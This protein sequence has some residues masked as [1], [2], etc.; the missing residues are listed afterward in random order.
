MSLSASERS[1]IKGLKM[2]HSFS[3][4]EKSEIASR[5][6][7]VEMEQGETLFRSGDDAMS[8]YV[9][10]KGELEIWLDQ[11]HIHEKV[12]RVFPGD[13]FGHIAL[14]DGGQRSA[15]CKAARTSVVLELSMFDFA[16]LMSP[17]KPLGFKFLRALTEIVVNQMRTTNDVLTRLAVKEQASNRPRPPTNPDLIQS[18]QEAAG[19][20]VASHI[21]GIDLNDVEVVVSDAD[22]HRQYNRKG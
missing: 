4:E 3:S 15:M 2:F 21:G 10:L 20:T 9:L 1:F 7:S 5:F 6:V 16:D 19:M 11:E 22:Q 12:S 8:C 18:I 17:S 13:I 14:L